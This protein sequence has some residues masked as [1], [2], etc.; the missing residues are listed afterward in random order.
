MVKKL[1]NNISLSA[2]VAILMTAIVACSITF[3]VTARDAM[4]AS[5]KPVSIINGDVL[6]LGGQ[7]WIGDNNCFQDIL[8]RSSSQQRQFKG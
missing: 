1:W 7:A 3:F 2:K 6:T 4:A 5:L 8:G